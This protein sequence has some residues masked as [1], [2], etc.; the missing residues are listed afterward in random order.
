MLYYIYNLFLLLLLCISNFL[1]K[2]FFLSFE[3]D[4]FKKDCSLHSVLRKDSITFRFVHTS[5]FLFQLLFIERQN[6]K[7]R[8]ESWK[9]ASYNIRALDVRL[10]F[11]ARSNK[12]DSDSTCWWFVASPS[13]R[14]CRDPSTVKGELV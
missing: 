8:V 4:S 12:S 6:W 11:Q 1:F 9:V 10:T 7:Y 2:I 5:H 13:P 14:K 3:K